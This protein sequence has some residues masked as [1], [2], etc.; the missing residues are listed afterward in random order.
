MLS[1]ESTSSGR[2]LFKLFHLWL[3]V[4]HSALLVTFTV[5][6]PALQLMDFVGTRGWSH[7]KQPFLIPPTLPV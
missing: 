4:T 1:T 3:L 6:I 7:F 5:L 2:K